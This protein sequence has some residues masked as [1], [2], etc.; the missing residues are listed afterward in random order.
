MKL[1][2][3][4]LVFLAL[5]Y[6]TLAG[7]PVYQIDE[8]IV[9]VFKLPDK[10]NHYKVIEDKISRHRISLHAAMD[11]KELRKINDN[12]NEQARSDGRPYR[13]DLNRID[14]DNFDMGFRY[15]QF[16]ILFIPVWNWDKKFCGYLNSKEYVP[17]KPK[18]VDQLFALHNQ[19]KPSFV[20][21][22]W[23]SIFGKLLLLFLGFCY[24]IHL[25]QKSSDSKQS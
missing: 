21:P 3:L 20:L 22:L 16:S 9:R 8:K 14:G 4:F 7:L 12:I 5:P 17:L 10:L 15:K 13:G 23:E 18:V 19:E 24:L 1:S 6:T 25:S 2:L 11:S